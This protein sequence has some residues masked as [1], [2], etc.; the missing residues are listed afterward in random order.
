MTRPSA[1]SIRSF[2]LSN[3]KPI[4]TF[5]IN[6]WYCLVSHTTIL[7]NNGIKKVKQ[8]PVI[9]TRVAL[10]GITTE[11]EGSRDRLLGPISFKSRDV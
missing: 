10:V 9:I 6:F 7:V 11:V 4:N 1:I 3:Q 2:H 8:K 5:V